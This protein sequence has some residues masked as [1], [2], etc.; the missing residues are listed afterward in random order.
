[1]R[2]RLLSWLLVLTMVVS[3]IPSTLVTTAFAAD[4]TS[5]QASGQAGKTVETVDNKWPGSLNADIT[6]VTITSSVAPGT[7]LFVKSGKTL[8]FHGNGY[9]AGASA[10]IPLVVVEDGGHLVLDDLII[11]NNKVGEKGAIYVE[12]GG[13]LDLG[14]ND[15]KERRAPSIT[16]N[17]YSMVVLYLCWIMN[18][19]PVPF[20]ANWTSASIYICIFLT[21][22]VC[23]IGAIWLVVLNTSSKTDVCTAA[24]NNMIIKLVQIP[25]Y[26]LLFLVGVVFAMFVFTIFITF[27]IILIDV[28]AISLSGI[29]GVFVVCKCGKTGLLKVDGAVLFSLS[30]FVFCVDVVCAVLLYPQ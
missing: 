18:L 20:P 23:G 22:L 7:T 21:W 27:S 2:K 17:T 15:Q 28:M 9:L 24:R 5:A 30:Q 3:L 4:N 19:L 14:Y 25:A 12:K 16:A 29:N 6:D 10:G 8:I 26:I 11:Q 1:M 13:L